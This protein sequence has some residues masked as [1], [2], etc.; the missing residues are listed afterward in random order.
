M[1]GSR[2]RRPL[3]NRLDL[4]PHPANR[5]IYRPRPRPRPPLPLLLGSL[6]LLS[7]LPRLLLLCNLLL[8]LLLSPLA[9]EPLLRRDE[10]IPREA[11]LLR[12]LDGVLRGQDEDLE[13]HLGGV[14]AR[15]G[16][17]GEEVLQFALLAGE[18]GG[19]AAL[20]G[21]AAGQVGGGG[22]FGAQEV[23]GSDGLLGYVAGAG[24]LGEK[25]VGEDVLEGGAVEICTVGDGRFVHF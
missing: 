21:G 8:V 4:H 16:G 20:A 2:R 22:E 7:L 11:L 5:H 19:L 12:D 23:D 24:G 15:G 13:K 17:G 9:P 3:P 18:R 10:D 14:D 25:G 1:H 6:T